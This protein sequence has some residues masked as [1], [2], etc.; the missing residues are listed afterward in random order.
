MKEAT[1]NVPL[2]EMPPPGCGLRTRT[3]YV[4]EHEMVTVR[5]ASCALIR[6]P[7]TAPTPAT[8]PVDVRLAVMVTRVVANVPE[9]SALSVITAGFGTVAGAV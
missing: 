3:V 5:T 1:L 9:L 8:P 4:P 6:V 2:P 7:P